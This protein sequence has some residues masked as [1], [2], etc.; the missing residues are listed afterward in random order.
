MEEGYADKMADLEWADFEREIR[1]RLEDEKE[2]EASEAST[3][4]E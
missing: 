4:D 2:M 3:D 1:W